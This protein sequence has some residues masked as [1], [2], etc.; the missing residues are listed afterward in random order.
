MVAQGSHASLGAFLEAM[1]MQHTALGGNAFDW[2]RFRQTKICVGVNSE[3]ELQAIY[4]K[5]LEAGL[6]TYLV[7]DAGLTEFKQPTYTAVAIG[8]AN[9]EEIDKITGILKLL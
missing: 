8:P 9:S 1:G 3:E 2:L 7:L 6:P 5:A 4:T